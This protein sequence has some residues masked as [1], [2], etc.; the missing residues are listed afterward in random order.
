MAFT[1]RTLLSI[2]RKAELIKYAKNHSGIGV[3]ALAESFGIGKTT[4]SDILKN[5]ET[6]LAAYE[7][8]AST[9][10]KMSSV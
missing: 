8:N 10:K 7:C 3:R 4:V 5:S 9:S 2:E 6:I 1:K